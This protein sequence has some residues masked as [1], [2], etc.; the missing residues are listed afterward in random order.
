MYFG[1]RPCGERS[2]F[3][4][5]L[6]LQWEFGESIAHSTAVAAKLCAHVL[7]LKQMEMMKF[8]A[9]CSRE[10]PSRPRVTVMFLFLTKVAPPTFD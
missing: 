1:E 8:D 10:H 3:V 6:L 2:S 4:C 5:A 7:P 9:F